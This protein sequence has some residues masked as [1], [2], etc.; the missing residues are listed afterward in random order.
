MVVLLRDDEREALVQA[1]RELGCPV[2][3]LV[4]ERVFSSAAGAQEAGRQATK[5]AVL[6]CQARE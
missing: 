2:S 3:A 4:R 6:R 1:A 5:S